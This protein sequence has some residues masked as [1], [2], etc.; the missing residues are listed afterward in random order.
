MPN[1]FESGNLAWFWYESWL[2]G[3][4]P[5]FALAALIHARLTIRS[6]AYSAS[7]QVLFVIGFIGALPLAVE[8]LGLNLGGQEE[9]MAVLSFIGAAGAAIYAVLRFSAVRL[10][11]LVNGSR[12]SATGTGVSVTNGA[13]GADGS[14]A[15]GGIP[16]GTGSSGMTSFG[17]PSNSV[18]AWLHFRS[19]PA[20]GQS[21]PLSAGVTR[22]G[23]DHSNDIVIN[24]PN[25]S[26]NHAEIEFRGGQYRLRDAG[27]SGG[28]MFDGASVAGEMLLT[29]GATIKLGD[30]ELMFTADEPATEFGS[31]N[32][33][34]VRATTV[35]ALRPAETMLGSADD[36][37]D[38]LVAWLAITSGPSKGQICQL[39]ADRTTIG[40]DGSN[41]LVISDPG[42]SRS[43][44]VV[45]ARDDDL[46]LV[47]LGSTGGTKVN[48]RSVAG[49]QIK[50]GARIRVG[51]TELELVAV[52][53]S[54][55]VQSA[56][57]GDRTVLDAPASGG[58]V[59]VRSGP[60]AGRTFNLEDGDNLVGRDRD[61]AVELTDPSVSRRHAIIRRQPGGYIVYDLASK[62]GTHV[63]GA[64][65]AGARLKPGDRIAVGHTELSL[66]R[67][68]AA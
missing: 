31:I 55:P 28:T 12:A 54:A 34:K 58:V 9:Y 48:G 10:F 35:D 36:A 24:D 59:V 32:E 20:A 17:G 2:A 52:E 51:D 21:V 37:D 18:P 56:G 68:R 25:V 66:M 65:L 30:T 61:S 38:R 13:R 46:V 57:S 7:L 5:M 23:R 1:P 45:I 47:D 27:S 19:G 29:S 3:I 42:V 26:R 64:K 15:T 53:T 39:L 50:N 63:D 22:L 43:H 4:V 40:R 33:V 67:P 44:A 11:R 6:R 16:A 60:D 41:H 8:R 14:I 62:T 49:K